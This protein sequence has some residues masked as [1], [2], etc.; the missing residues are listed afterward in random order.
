MAVALRDLDRGHHPHP[1]ALRVIG[2][3]AP[4]PPTPRSVYRR[5]RLAVLVLALA[6][7]LAAATAVGAVASR[8]TS[9]PATMEMIVVVSPGET[10]W[11]I[12]GRYAPPTSDR[13]AWVVDVAARNDIDPA[14]VQP[15]TPILVPVEAQSVVADPHVR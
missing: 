13:S 9:P 11:D 15:G 6:V 2:P 8:T 10:L 12:A 1:P 3:G 7:V 14:A 5:R 4:L